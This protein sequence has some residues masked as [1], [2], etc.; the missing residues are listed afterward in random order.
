M[1][2]Y[3]NIGTT[4][5]ST[6]VHDR[7]CR[8]AIGYQDA[9]AERGIVGG[10]VLSAGQSGRRGGPA[11]NRG[12]S[13]PGTT[14]EPAE[15]VELADL[16]TAE[17]DERQARQ[18]AREIAARL[19]VPRPRRDIR[20]RRGIGELESVPYRGSSD[21]IDL[22]RTLDVLAATPMPEDDDIIVRER[23]RTRRSVVLV[24]DV[25][26]SMKGERV[27]TAAAT[28]GALAGELHSGPAGRGGVLVRRRG[29]EVWG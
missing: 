22:D 15:V 24:V 17:T 5:L 28:V 20:A 27:R 14:D 18:R 7:L 29:A 19:A 11:R 3:D 25:S 26:G 21:D 13:A 4:R 16:E 6:S 1:N 9:A 23:E 8:L 10:L 2:P 12:G